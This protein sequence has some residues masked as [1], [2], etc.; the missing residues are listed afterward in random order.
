MDQ[1]LILE[2]VANLTSRAKE[3]VIAHDLKTAR[4][5]CLQGSALLEG[6]VLIKESS[7]ES[8]LNL[9][10]DD[11]GDDHSRTE[12]THYLRVGQQMLVNI[13]KS[14]SSKTVAGTNDIKK[15]QSIVSSQGSTAVTFGTTFSSI[16]GCEGAKCSL[17]E[18]VVLPFTCSEQAKA[19]VFSGASLAFTLK[20][21][22]ILVLT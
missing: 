6:A 13:S 5:Y 16:V 12:L 15:S 20:R 21:G 2:K 14:L 19:T 18:N 8:Q 22:Q 10:D 11:R 1:K 7:L 3:S 17:F 9:A 4:D